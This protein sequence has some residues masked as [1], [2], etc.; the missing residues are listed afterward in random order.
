MALEEIDC[1][2]ALNVIADTGNCINTLS[3][4]IIWNIAYLSILF[5][6]TVGWTLVNKIQI[7]MMV[8]GFVMT[9]VG[10]G[11]LGLGYLSVISIMVSI[12]ICIFGIFLTIMLRN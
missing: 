2:L 10:I 3:D 6:F 7:G 8:G 5:I 4:G 11:L 12:I 1:L 9:F